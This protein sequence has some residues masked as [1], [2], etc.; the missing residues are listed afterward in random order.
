MS[1]RGRWTSAIPQGLVASLEGADILYNTYW[2][3]FAR[4]G[5]TH[6]TAVEN[7]RALLRAAVEARVRRVVHI[8]ITNATQDSP[9]P[10]FR[11][12]APGGDGCPRLR[13]VLCHRPAYCAVQS[14]RHIDQQHRLVP[15]PVP[16]YFPSPAVA[17]TQCSR[18]SSTTSRDWR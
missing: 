6:D 11:G 9:L 4:G 13:A 18:C 2:V 10:Y 5:I 7:S 8:S 12:K 16:H 3:R 1:R 17:V 15:A 14:R